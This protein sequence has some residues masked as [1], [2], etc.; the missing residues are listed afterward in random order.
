MMELKLK[1]KFPLGGFL[2]GGLGLLG[3]SGFYLYRK[4]K[5]EYKDGGKTSRARE[6]KN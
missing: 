3:Y 1:D 5:V 2:L 4:N 6:G